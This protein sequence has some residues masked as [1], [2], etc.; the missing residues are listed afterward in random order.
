M[1]KNPNAEYA[2]SILDSIYTE[3]SVYICVIKCKIIGTIEQDGRTL[4]R[5]FDERMNWERLA[6]LPVE[7]LFDTREEA[8]TEAVKRATTIC[9]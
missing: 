3:D 1:L 9:P 5:L 4:Y 7:E 2:W 6:K 8:Y